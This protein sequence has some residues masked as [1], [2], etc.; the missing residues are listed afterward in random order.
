MLESF[1]EGVDII[2]SE[3]HIKADRFL[4]FEVAIISQFLCLLLRV[5]L[6]LP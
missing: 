3:L 6:A 4:F 2:D 5:L 1:S